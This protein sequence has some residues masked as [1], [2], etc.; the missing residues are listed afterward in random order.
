[1]GD[2][3]TACDSFLPSAWQFYFSVV[4]LRRLCVPQVLV[5]FFLC[6]GPLVIDFVFH[7]QHPSLLSAVFLHCL[8][9]FM[10]FV[11][12]PHPFGCRC[13]LRTRTV[14]LSP[15]AALRRLPCDNRLR[16]PPGHR[17]Y[18]FF[19]FLVPLLKFYIARARAR[20][21]WFLPPVV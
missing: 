17:V 7:P 10:P 1:M 13:R 11:F 20:S 15:L 4:T 19:Y 21:L 5:L 3:T 18:G 8:F 14:C 9:L 2:A 12:F 6:L 16:P